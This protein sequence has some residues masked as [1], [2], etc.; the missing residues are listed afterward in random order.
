MINFCAAILLLIYSTFAIAES[1]HLDFLGAKI[2]K[3]IILENTQEKTLLQGYAA[4][5]IGENPLYV[6]ALF[7]SKTQKEAPMLLL[8]ELS[9]V[10]VFFFL[11]DDVSSEKVARIFTEELLLNNPGWDHRSLNKDRLNELKEVFQ[12][13]MNAGDKIT[14][15][16]ASNGMLTVSINDKAVKN[17]KNS[18]SLFSALLKIWI[19][20]YPPSRAFKENILGK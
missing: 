4:N 2:P 5:F 11:Q 15:E 1:N 19:G 20:P 9:M 14:F 8:E 7:T 10:M 3:Q 18:R 13:T 12:Q 6:G 17:W 16:Y